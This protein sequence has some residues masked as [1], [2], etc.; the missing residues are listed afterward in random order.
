M[1]SVVIFLIMCLRR[2]LIFILY[3]TQ[4]SRSP[5]NIILHLPSLSTYNVI[6]NDSFSL[7]SYILPPT[8][9][10]HPTTPTS[11][12]LANEK[13]RRHTCIQHSQKLIVSADLN[14][15]SR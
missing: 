2:I 8:S 4:I 11:S 15:D 14:N 7:T 13:L 9:S 1:C 6:I 3:Y 10:A 12:P 5:T